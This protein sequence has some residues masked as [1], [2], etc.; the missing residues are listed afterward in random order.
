MGMFRRDIVIVGP[1][2]T[3]T[4]T[5]QFP[6]LPANLRKHMDRTTDIDL[7][8]IEHMECALDRKHK[9]ATSLTC[10]ARVDGIGSY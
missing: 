3:R 6:S 1:A 2:C 10:H 4:S 5:Q 9:S 7:C 8:P